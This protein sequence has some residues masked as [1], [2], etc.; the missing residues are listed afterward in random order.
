MRQLKCRQQWQLNNEFVSNHSNYEPSAGT[1]IFFD[2]DGDGTIDYVG[3]VEKCENGVVYTVEGNSGD[4][5]KKQQYPVGGGSIYGYGVPK[6][7]ILKFIKIPLRNV[8]LVTL[9]NEVK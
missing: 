4:A 2:W 3:I 7:K 5:C 9:R 1:I 8:L 6:Y